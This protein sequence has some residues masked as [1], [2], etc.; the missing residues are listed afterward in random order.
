MES[1]KHEKLGLKSRS[2]KNKIKS[3]SLSAYLIAREPFFSCFWVSRSVQGSG[4][5]TSFP[6]KTR[7][8]WE[9]PVNY[10]QVFLIFLKCSVSLLIFTSSILVFLKLYPSFP[11]FVL[12]NTTELP[13]FF[14]FLPS[15][16]VFLQG[17]RRFV[18][19]FAYMVDILNTCYHFDRSRSLPNMPWAQRAANRL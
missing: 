5:V 14:W 11:D 17:L 7:K 2:T 13:K 6:Q 19:G 18:P 8:N 3:K 12:V 4:V 1:R 16:L 15:F 9:Q 10:S